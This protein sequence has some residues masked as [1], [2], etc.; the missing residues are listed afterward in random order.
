MSQ[1]LITRCF[2]VF[3]PHEA[4]PPNDQRYVECS[5]ERGSVGLFDAMAR[6]IRRAEAH[7]CQLLSGHRGCGK[8][9]ELFRL[10]EGL[11]MEEPR[12][13]VVYCE[14][15][16]YI[17]LNDVEFSDVLLAVIQ[18]LWTDA[19]EKGIHLEP[20][21]LREVVDE[22]KGI[23]TSTVSP[24]DISFGAGIAKLSFEIKT[25]PNNRQIVRAYLRPRATSLLDAVNEVLATAEERVKSTGYSGIVVIVDNLDRIFRNPI[26]NTNRNSQEA[27]FIDASSYLRGLSCDLIYTVPPAL[28]YSSSGAKLPGLY[29]S[30]HTMLPMI[31]V[32]TRN[33]NV[34]ELGI[35]KLFEAIEKRLNFI[36]ASTDQ[37]FDSKDTV[38][39]VCRASG[40]Y[41]RGLMTLVRAA[42]NYVDALPITGDAVEQTIRDARNGYVTSILTSK[43]WQI[44]RDI[45]KSKPILEGEDYL[46]L[47]ENF[48]ILEYRDADGPWYDVNPVIREA[49]E[50]TS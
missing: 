6:T 7:T 13:F 18:Q 32:A 37:A 3:D 31:P 45:A 2:N 50:F 41:V 44:L 19:K 43:R 1:D 29:G 27:L 46:Q 25:N 9:T 21:R 48:A 16:E 20:G 26:P 34:D 24:K 39:R 35:G 42:T 17:D 8:T 23:L 33:G 28:L 4:L 30:L 36:D 38:Q 22:V 47:L 10:K 12:H 11:M 15:N 5:R 14:A 40:G 49:R